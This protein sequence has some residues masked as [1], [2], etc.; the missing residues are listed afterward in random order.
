[1]KQNLPNDN[2]YLPSA[3]D[4]HISDEKQA[5]DWSASE[6]YFYAFF[7]HSPIA[8][9]LLNASQQ[10]VACNDA[11][12]TLFA[13]HADSIHHQWYTE[14]L[15]T[16]QDPSIIA[17]HQTHLQEV[18]EVL[19]GE[20]SS[21]EGTFSYC[22]THQRVFSSRVTISRMTENRGDESLALV[23]FHDIQQHIEQ[24]LQQPEDYVLL[25]EEM[26]RVNPVAISIISLTSHRY[27]EVNEAFLQTF[28]FE[29]HEVVGYALE[30]VAVCPL[31]VLPDV[32]TLPASQAMCFV[33]RKEIQCQTRSGKSLD[34]MLSLNSIQQGKSIYLLVTFLDLTE[35]KQAE[36][37]LRLAKE[38]A[39]AAAQA[40]SD[41]MA[42]MSHELRTPLN[43]VINMTN[44]LL[45]SSLTAQ[46][47]EFASIVS[48][49]GKSLLS[50]VNDVLD[51][52][53]MEAGKLTLDYAPFHLRSCIE[54][55]VDIV[56]TK[57]D[58]KRIGFAY[59]LQQ[60]APEFLVGDAQRIQQILINLL[61]NGIKFTD[62]GEVVLTVEC[63]ESFLRGA[64]FQM[65]H[66]SVQDTGVGIPP[67]RMNRLFHSFSQA[68]TS[69][70]RKYGG[71]GL[72]LA[73]SKR[74][75]ELMGG[76]I[77]A[78]SE[79]GK[80]STF[81]FAI[82]IDSYDGEI[83]CSQA[84][85]SKPFAILQDTQILSTLQGK[86]ILVVSEEST[87]Y[88]ILRDQLTCWGL[89]VDA[90]VSET[91]IHDDLQNFQ[92]S[93]FDVILID[94]MNFD[95][96]GVTIIPLLQHYPSLRD[97]PIV[98]YT[99]PSQY[100]EIASS[101]PQGFF[102]LLLRPMKPAVLL[103]TLASLLSEN[104]V[105]EQLLS[106]IALQPEPLPVHT[107]LSR[108]SSPFISPS[109]LRILIVEDNEIN[110]KVAL[111]LLRK[112][113]YTADVACNGKEALDLFEQAN[114]D[115]V[116][117]DVQMPEMDGIEATIQI[118]TRL[119]HHCQPY[120]IAMTAHALPEDRERC[121]AAGM[122]D[123]LTKPVSLEQLRTTLHQFDNRIPDHAVSQSTPAHIPMTSDVLDVA[124][125]LVPQDSIQ[126][127]VI[128]RSVLRNLEESLG[129][130]SVHSLIQ[131][132]IE[133]YL[134]D[135][136][137]M[138]ADM[139]TAMESHDEETC[140]R[141]AHTLKSSSAQMG[142]K[143]LH[144]LCK[145]LESSFRGGD[146]KQFQPLLVQIEHEFASVADD[147]Q[148]ITNE[149]DFL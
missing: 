47:Y 94:V 140:I 46:Q 74:L 35:H 49:S 111:N 71:T 125:S 21:L 100:G 105:T 119:P 37:A 136:P 6:H 19:N 41:F 5:L 70:T 149:P 148:H 138:I 103:H 110:Q 13:C 146:I 31:S 132:L 18:L 58:E 59:T 64:F 95:L 101:M 69:M 24:E 23:M 133:I 8:T 43:A 36:V 72:G 134:T 93:T 10:I 113:G 53:K 98:L 9:L 122:N 126:Y 92:N 99:F 128:D 87:C 15:A 12:C 73:I 112:I 65:L 75:T 121:L 86:R 51:F 66:V 142:A 54:Q 82:R 1:M 68:D 104:L 76:T 56:A 4:R 63:E 7:G 17:Q 55:A 120:I 28:E 147:L 52:S 88:T 79:E 115:V 130:E 42:N 129:G 3:L 44:L 38:T 2:V 139:Y 62:Y 127:E 107:V 57:V 96:D 84:D 26:F 33:D 85:L 50:V 61:S 32:S 106:Q 39:E 90:I 89:E 80:G 124:P 11:C 27:I 60:G 20:R 123:Y 109:T 16:S 29:R 83:S 22:C 114:Y 144:T 45:E 67:D 131:E 48:V 102:A 137:K 118:R 77:W 34:M 97:V 135:S 30:D 14:L 25:L 108:D 143:K 81:R 78:E 40:K 117:M 145:E 141:L 116:L 91:Q